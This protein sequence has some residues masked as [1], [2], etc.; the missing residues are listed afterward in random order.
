MSLEAPANPYIGNLTVT[1]PTSS[2]PKSQGDDHIRLMKGAMQDTFAGFSAQVICRGTES[3]S[4]N[5]YTVTVSSNT[6]FAAYN[7]GMMVEF[8]A[9]HANTGACTLQVNSLGTKTLKGVDGAALASGD[10]EN[11]GVVLAYYDGTDFFLL[12]GNDRVSRNGDTITGN[13]TLTGNQT[14]GGTLGVTGLSTL[15]SLTVTGA[16][17]FPTQAA[18]DNTQSAATT[19]FV[20]AAVLGA[21]V[22]IPGQTNMGS[23]AI[24]TDGTSAN[25]GIGP[26]AISLMALDIQ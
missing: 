15:A 23:L 12:S 1:N 22:T 21:S 2:D 14:I 8:K 13:L 17:T 20:T 19:A 11:G 4:G 10:I 25:W 16:N 9:T 24:V 6:A 5:A 7:T 3:G 26:A 18:G